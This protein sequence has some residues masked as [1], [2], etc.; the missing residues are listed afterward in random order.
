M[1]VGISVGKYVPVR[2]SPDMTSVFPKGI[3]FTQEYR[4]KQRIHMA[5]ITRVLVRPWALQANKMNQTG[6][7]DLSCLSL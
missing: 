5:V 6:L 7:E 1:N 2:L 4:P 3:Q